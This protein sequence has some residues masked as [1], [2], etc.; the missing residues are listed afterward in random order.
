M[1]E[2]IDSLDSA[3]QKSAIVLLISAGLFV[4]SALVCH[5]L[6]LIASDSAHNANNSHVNWEKGREFSIGG[7]FICGGGFLA[8]AI[9]RAIVSIDEE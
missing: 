6:S 9:S 8:C 4:S 7:I 3:L 1:K 5:G 2:L